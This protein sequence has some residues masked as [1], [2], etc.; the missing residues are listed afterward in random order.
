MFVEMTDMHLF[1]PE[2]DVLGAHSLTLSGSDLPP[3]PAS[4]SDWSS[5]PILNLDL[6]SGDAWENPSPMVVH[7]D[8][9]APVTSHDAEWLPQPRASADDTAAP[10]PVADA[11]LPAVIHAAVD[12]SSSRHPPAPAEARRSTVSMMHS[13]G[14]GFGAVQKEVVRHRRDRSVTVSAAPRPAGQDLARSDTTPMLSR[15]VSSDD[16]DVP[17]S[18]AQCNLPV[19]PQ[20]MLIHDRLA[21]HPR[22]FRCSVCRASLAVVRGHIFEGTLYCDDHY[23]AV[24]GL[25]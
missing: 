20:A 6:R 17:R 14:P 2:G 15:Q 9:D 25:D 24:V 16:A 19:L 5:N 1:L 13:P 7:L 11:R 23:R 12:A 4:L 3:L 18:C 10:G 8:T 21:F 22:C